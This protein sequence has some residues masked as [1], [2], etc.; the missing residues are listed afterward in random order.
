ASLARFAGAVGDRFT[1]VAAGG[2]SGAFAGLHEGAVLNLGLP[3][4]AGPQFA[5]RYSGGVTLTQVETPTR[6]E[7]LAVTPAALEAGGRVVLSG[8][9]TDPDRGDRL[10]LRVDWDDGTAVRTYHPGVKPFRLEHRYRDDRAA[11]YVIHVTW[12]D[13]HGQGNSRD[14]AV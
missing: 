7:D 2:F 13:E 5:V 3:P 10:T 6:A 11:A 8:R 14:L 1:I 12:F 9:L 4:A